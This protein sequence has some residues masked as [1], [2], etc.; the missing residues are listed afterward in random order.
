MALVRTH[1]GACQTLGEG[2]IRGGA[3]SEARKARLHKE[4]A[5]TVAGGECGREVQGQDRTLTVAGR[6]C[7]REVQG[8]L[9]S[10][11]ARLPPVRDG[12]QFHGVATVWLQ[13]VQDH[14]IV[15]LQEKRRFAKPVTNRSA[16]AT[17]LPHRARR[18]SGSI[19]A[20]PAVH[21]PLK[22]SS[23][24]IN[25]SRTPK[26]IIWELCSLSNYWILFHEYRSE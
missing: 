3:H 17:P 20:A 16:S 2:A 11:Q 10:F 26:H 13:S 12:L 9:R 15:G 24:T 23:F 19:S 4:R 6:A 25:I 22:K 8:R 7:G 18:S 14:R 5:L 21:V 1:R